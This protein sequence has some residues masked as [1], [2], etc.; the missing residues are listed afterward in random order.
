MRDRVID[1]VTNDYVSNGKGS[2]TTTT[3]A[4]TKCY[5]A[6]KVARNTWVGRPGQGA[7]FH[8]LERK[9][10]DAE[11]ARAEAMLQKALQPLIEAG[12]IANLKTERTRDQAQRHVL[13][14]IATDVQ[15]GAPIAGAEV[16]P[17]GA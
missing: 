9:D 15:S 10:T 13:N 12:V 6:L 17:W 4:A 7:D 8:L 3:T 2:W 11:L 1:P 5:L 14:W 16:L